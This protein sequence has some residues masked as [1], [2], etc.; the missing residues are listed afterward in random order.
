MLA[1]EARMIYAGASVA[2]IVRIETMDSEKIR[3]T[4][5]KYWG[6]DSFLPLQEETIVHMFQ[7]RESLT[8]LPTG[9]GKSL[10]YQ[11]P[12][13]LSEGMAV[14]VSPLISLMKDQVDTLR[15][16]GIDTE[17]LHSGL[18]LR[19]QDAII[20]RIQDGRVKILY[21]APER[22]NQDSMLILLRQLKLSFF[23]V[24]EAHCISHWGHDFRPEY[25]RLKNLRGIFPQVSMHAFTATATPEVSRDIC[26]ELALEKAAI[27]VGSVDRANLTYRLQPRK[28]LLRHITE[29]L[30]K[31]AG[32]A[33]IIYCLRRR[34]VETVSSQLQAAGFTNVRYHAG[35]SD[36]ERQRN[37]DSFMRG[38][39]DLVVAT[40]AFG[41]GID[42]SD[43]RFIIH[44]AMPKSIEHYQQETGRA[45]RDGLAAHCYLFYG[46]GDFRLWSHFAEESI[47]KDV[48]MKKLSAM[49]NL[50]THP[51]CRH[52]VLSE[53][54]GQTYTKKSCQACDYCLNEV[55]MVEEPLIVAQKILSCVVRVWKQSGYGFGAEHITTI[56]KGVRT[57]KIA[58]HGHDT[59]STFGIMRDETHAYI[60]FM[61]EQL[62]GQQCLERHP[63]Y[64]ILRLGPAGRALLRSE[65]IPVLAKPLVSRKKKEVLKERTRRRAAE[66]EGIDR[67]LF[68]SLKAK[69]YQ[70]AQSK[71]VPPYIIFSDR[72]LKD[73]ALKKPTDHATFATVFGVGQSKHKA[74]ADIFIDVITA[75][76]NS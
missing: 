68:S 19:E 21:V 7:S 64:G 11:L 51:Q 15:A 22:I 43:I 2:S 8:V 25:R 36:K 45:G 60:R 76:P 41:M 17:C 30:K 4:L 50:C 24:D 18:N 54:F 6:Y 57:D 62:I 56:L 67:D 44:A 29:L 23:I 46:G 16:M 28:T 32:E 73:M 71:G 58:E 27:L 66:W 52:R 74:Y 72:T 40:I 47:N 63:P 33:G 13:V 26:T 5:K 9:G 3:A 35:L 59:I 65:R 10:C 48:M 12:A 53:Y 20:Q 37:Q 55:E 39:V 42:R 49:Y 75:F 61:I 1:E 70:I 34:D 14:V 31:H 38:R 69:R